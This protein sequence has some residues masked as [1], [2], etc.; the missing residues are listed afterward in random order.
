MPSPLYSRAQDLVIPMTAATE[1]RELLFS[2]GPVRRLLTV[3]RGD[4]GALRD[5]SADAGDAGD[6]DDRA[7]LA[8]VGRALVL[9]H[10]PDLSLAAVEG[11]VQ[12]DVLDPTPVVERVVCAVDGESVWRPSSDRGWTDREEVRPCP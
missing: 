10:R 8:S 7:A 9:E 6:V 5:Q 2:C 12:V 1:L 3:L 4:V 11:A